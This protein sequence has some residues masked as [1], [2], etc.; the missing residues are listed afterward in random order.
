VTLKALT[1]SPTGGIVAAPTTSLPEALGGVRNWDY[2]YC[3]VRDATF[4][5]LALVHNGFIDEGRAWREWL[6]RAVAGDSSKLQILYGVDGTRRVGEEEVPWLRGYEGARPVRVGNAASKQRQLDVYGEIM[7]AM[8]QCHKLGLPPDPH[9][10]NVRRKLLEFLET[11]WDRPDHGIWEVR[12]PSRQFTHSKI[13]AWVAFDRG[14]KRIEELGG[15]GPLERWRALRARVHEE[16]CRCGFDAELGAFVQYYGS[17]E[18][19]ASLLMMPLV[20]FL[21]ASDP[22]VRGTVRAIEENL[23]DDGLVRRYRSR[24]EVDG[25]PEG[26]GVFLPCTFW[27]A[28][29]LAMAGRLSDARR[30]FDRLLDLRNDVGL[31]SE[32]YDVRAGRLVG[33]FPQAFS[34]VSLVNTARHLT[35]AEAGASA[36]DAL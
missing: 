33:N 4:T 12:G 15:E 7:D 30:L 16:I 26:E 25:L 14:V 10:W 34:H 20:G 13:M 36:R 6:L 27:L 5:L 29:N 24:S 3:W 21:P 2:R 1:H 18:L 9:A 17:K 8:Y 22:R 23:M 19:D 32:E 31:L 35:L 11:C 28:D